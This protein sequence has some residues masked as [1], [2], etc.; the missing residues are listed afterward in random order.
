MAQ[1]EGT[2]KKGARC[3]R[4]SLEGSSF[5]NTHQGM[6]EG[7]NTSGSAWC[8]ENY[9]LSDNAK[10]VLGFVVVGLLILWSLR[11]GI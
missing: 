9:E 3:K 1:C 4:E 2:T 8:N 6:E 7:T 5:C 11:R 10:T